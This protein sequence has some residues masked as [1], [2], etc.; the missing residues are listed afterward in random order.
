MS[1]RRRNIFA[2]APAACVLVAAC[3]PVARASLV[4]SVEALTLNGNAV[5]DPYNVALSNVGDVLTFRL[6]ATV[7]GTDGNPTNDGLQTVSGS[8]LTTGPQLLGNLSTMTLAAPFIAS[9]SQSGA[10]QDLDSDGDLDLGSNVDSSASGFVAARASTMQTASGNPVANGQA[11]V[12]GTSSFTLT[13]A[14]NGSSAALGYRIRNA[15]GGGAASWQE[16]GAA[17]TPGT[18]SYTAGA[19][20]NLTFSGGPVDL[21]LADGATVTGNTNLSGNLIYNGGSSG[22]TITGDIALA[23]GGHTFNVADGS[24]DADVAVMGVVSGAASIT[25]TGNGTLVLSNINTY[26]N[27]TNINAGKVRVSADAN[28]GT[29]GITMG[30][31]TLEIVNGGTYARPTS[32]NSSTGGISVSTGQTVTWSGQLSGAG[33][34][35]LSGGGTFNPTGSNGTH[36][37]KYAVTGGSTL[38]YTLAAGEGAAPA[39]N[40]ADYFVLDNGTLAFEGQASNGITAVAA[41][42]GITVNP[43]GGTIAAHLGALGSYSV[44]YPGVITGSG[45]LTKAGAAELQLSGTSPNTHAGVTTVAAGTLTLNKTA[46]VAAVGGNVV[47]NAGAMLKWGAANQ[48][49]DTAS[50]TVAGGALNLNGKAETVASVSLGAGS[51]VTGGALTVGGTPVT[52]ANS[53]AEFSGTQGQDG[54]RYGFYNG[55]GA[56]PWNNADFEPL[57]WNGGAWVLDGYYT[58]LDAPGGHPNGDGNGGRYP[59]PQYQHAV[60]R[61]VSEVSGTVTLSGS[62]YDR[63]GGGGDGVRGYAIVDGVYYGIADIGNGGSTSYSITVP[64]SVGSLVDLAIDPKAHDAWDW[65]GF[66][67]TITTP[68]SGQVSLSDGSNLAAPLAVIGNVAYTGT[69][70]AAT[71]GGGVTLSSPSASITVADGAAATDLDVT[72]TLTATSTAITKGGAGNLRLAGSA[73]WAASGTTLTV[74]A[75]SVTLAANAGANGRKLSLNASGGNVTMQAT[76]VLSNLAI[77]AGATVAMQASGSRVLDIA[78]LSV[79]TTGTLDLADNKLILRYTSGTGAATLANVNTALRRGLNQTGTLWAGT[80]ITSSAAAVDTS[81]LRAYA[82]V[83]NAELGMP[84]FGGQAVD[85]NCL[86]GMYTYL[87]DANLDGTVNFDDFA[88]FDFYVG[89]TG[90]GWLHGDFNYDGLTDR[91][92]D[93]P[94]LLDS[95]YGQGGVMNDRLAAIVESIQSKA[96][97]EPSAAAAAGALLLV[98]CIIRGKRRHRRRSIEGGGGQGRVQFQRAEVLR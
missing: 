48:I 88:F 71:L 39:S 73:T 17:K 98:T 21:T 29:S 57:T 62:F 37:G 45:A 32:F 66:T 69:T 67:T 35:N 78:G 8:V 1:R 13:S 87:G 94:L 4:V 14:A 5:A 11:F 16:D 59:Y 24:A 25:K 38:K 28:L 47:V 61:W 36:T 52:V 18:G 75:G 76:Q 64:V 19:T 34:V 53:Q 46:G 89:T 51:T 77:G 44:D 55:N 50:V 23:S 60:R 72:G 10:V 40:T 95:Y 93:F 41:T 56:Q 91:E 7:T 20:V 15:T 74:A 9:G 31:G 58:A 92:N 96:V 79:A 6:V 81:R 42:R 49:P 68:L 22:A 86:L 33:P 12:I 30:G 63:D 82:V 43:G 90:G 70:S 84:T 54:W 85:P 27:L 80:G 97:P 65:T 3:A 26:T 83:D 2:A